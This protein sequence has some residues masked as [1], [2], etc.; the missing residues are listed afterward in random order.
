MIQIKSLDL[1]DFRN[2]EEAHVEFVPGINW[3]VGSNAQGKTNLLEA[4]SL[5]SLGRSFRTPHL[6]DLIRSGASSF[7]IRAVILKDEVEQTLT[8]TYDGKAKKI[9]L[10]GK[11]YDRFGPLIGFLPSVL[12]QPEDSALITGI[13]ALRRRFL[14]MH[15]AQSS[16]AYLQQLVRYYQAMKQRNAILKKHINAPLEPWE[17]LMAE[18]GALIMRMRRET[19][20]AL[21]E[22]LTKTAHHLSN[23][24]DDVRC[25]Y[26]SHVEHEDLLL[27]S[28]QEGLAKDKEMG[29]TRSG[30]HRD[31]LIFSLGES[32]AKERASQGQ[33]RT[34][35]AALKL[36]EWQILQ[37]NTGY[38]PLMQI[39][40]F[41][42]HLDAERK[43]KFRGALPQ[44]AQV[45]L[46]SPHEEAFEAH[47]IYIG[48]GTLVKS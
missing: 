30:P 19:I 11:S 2:Y 34:L 36:A 8:L 33:R 20:A 18:S 32:A 42:V 47:F 46:T 41:G 43:E 31:D 15:I 27:K 6:S 12:Y 16:P 1:R 9:E 4:L 25:H 21:S 29:I 24:E 38:P 40:D 45:F 26:E 48:G 14:D 7:A 44:G 13:P 28:W 22:M 39:D 37:R 23:G 5:L 35:V 3:I 17:E 10:S